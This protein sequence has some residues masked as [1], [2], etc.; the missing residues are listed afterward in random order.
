MGIS[1]FASPTGALTAAV[2]DVPNTPWRVV[3]VA[4]S[5]GLYSPAG[6][7][8]ADWA[9]WLAVA[10]SG[11]CGIGLFVRLGRAR[12]E[13]VAMAR[14][15]TLTGLSNRRAMQEA[16]IKTASL[17]SRHKHPLSALMIDIDHFKGINDVHGHDAG[18]VAIR[19]V[20]Q[21]LVGAIRQGDMAG[22]WGGEEF[23][24]L[25]P[26]TNQDAAREVAE[27]IRNRIVGTVHSNGSSSAPVTVSV[28]V[29]SLGRTDT[30]ALLRH[31]DT[32]LYAAKAR[33]RN[34]VEMYKVR[35]N[36]HPRVGLAPV[37]P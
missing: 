17:S 26:H 18:D 15:D 35:S 29:A 13:S 14:T 8:W 7:E 5:A 37:A 32:A 31:A 22:R 27:R 36:S 6:D 9:L 2:A 3:L 33:G 16:L 20:A 25:L 23:L 1:E 30:V 24:V 21:A 10:V 19:G 28:G 11:F 12:A 34:C 4:P